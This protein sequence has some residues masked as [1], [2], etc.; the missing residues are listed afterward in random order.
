MLI[1]ALGPR[2]AAS[3]TQALPPDSIPNFSHA[4]GV[5]RN[6]ARGTSHERWSQRK[7]DRVKPGRAGLRLVRSP[8]A[9]QPSGECS[10]TVIATFYAMNDSLSF[11]MGRSPEECNEVPRLIW[12]DHGTRR[13]DPL[14]ALYDYNV[15]AVWSAGHYLVLAL[16]ADYELGSH[17]ERLAFWDLNTGHIVSSPR[18]DWEVEEWDE[19]PKK[20]LLG[21]L[22]DWRQAIVEQAGDALILRYGSQCVEVWPASREFAPLRK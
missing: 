19:R 3:E 17:S 18:V 11:T 21:A 22:S 1:L 16:E 6:G 5:A 8:A 4:V 10:T 15:S 7:T 14:P 20:P 2:A 9:F 12:N 13:I